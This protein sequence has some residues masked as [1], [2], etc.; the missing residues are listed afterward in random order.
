MLNKDCGSK[1]D[2]DD[3][4]EEEEEGGDATQVVEDIDEAV[5]GVLV[6]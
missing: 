4:A 6:G 2:L 1:A 3:E 5:D